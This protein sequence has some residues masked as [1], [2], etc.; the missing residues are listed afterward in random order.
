L[1]EETGSVQ[2]MKTVTTGTNGA[3]RRRVCSE[4]GESKPHDE[5][6]GQHYSESAATIRCLACRRAANTAYQRKYRAER[7]ESVRKANLWR[8]YKIRPDDYDR[9]RTEQDGRCAICGTQE[10]DIDLSRVGGRPTRDGTRRMVFPLQVDHCHETG[11]IRG[12]LCPECN[13]GLGLFM[14]DAERLA[15]AARYVLDRCNLT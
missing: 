5:F 10:E 13:R 11:R 2:D 9:L 8:L 6:G 14:E 12:L 7:P 15:G 3:V 4:C 1:S